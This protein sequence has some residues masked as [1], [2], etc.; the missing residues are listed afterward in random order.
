M[1]RKPPENNISVAFEKLN[2]TSGIDS[3]IAL[4]NLVSLFQLKILFAIKNINDE[5][6][7]TDIE[8]IY[9]NISKIETT[10]VDKKNKRRHC[11]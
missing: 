11:N 1:S 2:I 7:R 8:S 10:N 4:E 5:K 6:N 9:N 3:D